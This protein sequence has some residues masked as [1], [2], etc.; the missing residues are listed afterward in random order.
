MVQDPRAEEGS[1]ESAS[2]Q[3]PARESGATYEVLPPTDSDAESD[4]GYNP[5]ERRKS[6]KELE[7]EEDD[8]QLALKLQQ[9]MYHDES[10]RPVAPPFQPHPPAARPP[11]RAE[12]P[13]RSPA[14]E[15]DQHKSLRGATMASGLTFE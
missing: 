1:E 12:P 3:K 13:E 9:E 15:H 11:R 8:Y 6:Q 2:V 14:E 7:Q 4:P 10:G 5:F